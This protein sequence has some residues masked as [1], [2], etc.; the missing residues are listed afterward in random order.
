MGLWPHSLKVNVTDMKIHI[1]RIFKNGVDSSL[2]I[3]TSSGTSGVYA[4]SSTTGEVTI[5]DYDY[6]SFGDYS[7]DYDNYYRHAISI[8]GYMTELVEEEIEEEYGYNPLVTGG[9]PQCGSYMYAE[10]K[11]DRK[12][13]SRKKRSRY[14]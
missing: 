13:G 9:C 5:S 11:G 14:G 2:S 8:S 4:V 10:R 1:N 6:V 12:Y 3:V 7:M